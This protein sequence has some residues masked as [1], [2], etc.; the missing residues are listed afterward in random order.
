MELQSDAQRRLLHESPP[1]PLL[2][3]GERRDCVVTAELKEAGQHTLVC[4]CT[5][6][7]ADGERRTSPQFFKF[8]VTQPFAVKTK[9]RLIPD[10]SA[11]LLEACVENITPEQINLEGISLE[12]ATSGWRLVET[13]PPPVPL[14]ATHTAGADSIADAAH[15]SSLIARQQ[16]LHPHGGARHAVFKLERSPPST[17]A[18]I[19][20]PLRSDAPS[21]PVTEPP[22]ALG[23]LEIRWR[24]RF[25][26]G[27]RLQTHTIT[28]GAARAKPVRIALSHCPPVATLEQ[29]FDITLRVTNSGRAKTG[30]LVLRALPPPP[31]A[32]TDPLP[33]PPPK[34]PHSHSHS[35]SGSWGSGGHGRSVSL[36]GGLSPFPSP[37]VA[38]PSPLPPP[39]PPPPSFPAIEA[40]GGVW[41][42]GELSAG[43]SRSVTVSCLP[44]A[45][46]MASLPR[47]QLC[48]E[49]LVALGS[50]RPLDVTGGEV[51]VVA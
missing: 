48:E 6:T 21:T 32:A 12:P 30:R 20:S 16:L 13:L 44:L 28:A 39:P 14:A 1:C 7:D 2:P 34:A 36:G 25:G 18:A 51:L 26:D 50:T 19:A 24:G 37:P 3:P 17:D 38:S 31:P 23:R 8:S 49:S 5:F 9:V 43:E 27:G 41:A 4:S 22:S 10:G 35:R 11:A 40:A 33:T 29:P 15:L 46:G 47:M 45:L 42:V